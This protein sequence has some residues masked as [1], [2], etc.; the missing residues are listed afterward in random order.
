MAS[1]KYMCLLIDTERNVVISS[2]EGSNLSSKIPFLPIHF[3]FDAPLAYFKP[4]LDDCPNFPQFFHHAKQKNS[5][6]E[7]CGGFERLPLA[8]SINRG[9]GH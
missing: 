6:R 7:H 4:M 3:L 8:H 2:L 1:S 5:T 9:C